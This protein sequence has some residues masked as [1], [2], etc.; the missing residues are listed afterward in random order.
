MV[1]GMTEAG[2]LD[3]LDR[4]CYEPEPEP[5]A[6]TAFLGR[7]AALADPGPDERLALTLG[8][9]FTGQLEGAEKGLCDVLGDLLRDHPE[10]AEAWYEFA[11][12]VGGQGE[13]VALLETALAI[14]PAHADAI[15]SLTRSAEHGWY[16]YNEY[17]IP[18]GQLIRYLRTGYETTKDTQDRL[19]FARLMYRA[20]LESGH[21]EAAEALQHRVRRDFGLD[22]LDYSEKRR[23]GSLQ[24]VCSFTMLYVLTEAC[25]AALESLF[26]AAA[27]D[28]VPVP[29]DVV[30]VIP[31]V[32]STLDYVPPPLP[33]NP[34][35]DYVERVI[36]GGL[37]ALPMTESAK[38]RYAARLKRAMESIAQPSAEHERVYSMFR[39]G[40]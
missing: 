21:P 34:S 36:V 13:T 11:Y 20:S 19:A 33:R 31:G 8:R 25:V 38:A 10:Y 18:A 26:I 7:L 32:L 4:Y 1:G 14:D 28:G 2:P 24:I 3:D 27:T 17:G 6:C 22:T 9:D 37:P 15:G 5:S 16:D 29:D 23:A 12:C 35:D 30:K 40:L 39:D